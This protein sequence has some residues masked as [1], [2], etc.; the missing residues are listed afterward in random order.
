[1]RVTQ[2]QTNFWGG[3]IAT[4]SQGYADDELYKAS[5]AEITNFVVTPNGGL[6][7]RPGTKFVARTKPNAVAQTKNG[8][9]VKLVPFTLG[10]SSTQNF[11]LEFGHYQSEVTITSV[12]H[13]DN[14]FT[15]SVGHGLSSYDVIQ[16]E[17]SADDL[18][19]GVSANVDYHV[20]KISD[21]TFKVCLNAANVA[22]TTVVALSDNG[23]GTHKISSRGYC[24]FYKDGAQVLLS[25]KAFE[26]TTPYDTA[27]KINKLNFAQSAAFIFLVSPDVKPQKLQYTA[28]TTWALSNI[29]FFDGPYFGTQEETD[30]DASTRT[31]A[32]Q[33][34]SSTL[35]SAAG[36]LGWV[37]E[38]DNGYYFTGTP[39]TN[40]NLQDFSFLQSKNPGL[41]DGMKIQ[42]SGTGQTTSHPKDQD[43]YATQCTANTFKLTESVGGAPIDFGIKSKPTVKAYFYRKNSTITLRQSGSGIWTNTATDAGRLFR[44]NTLGNDQIYWG[45]VEIQSISTNDAT[46]TVKTDIPEAYT[47]GLKDWKLGQWYTS[48]Y[49]HHVTL[50][51]QRLVFARVDHSPQTIF[52]SQTGDFFNFAA[53]E[54]LGSATGQ[55]TASG[56]SII[57]EQILAS[58]AMTFTFDSGTVDEIQ[59]LIAQEKLLAG[60]TGGIYTVYGSE[61]DLTITPINFTIKREGTQPAEENSNAVA[62]DENVI[63]IQGTGKRVRLVNFGDV[64]AASKSFDMTIRAN[65]ILDGQGKQVVATQIPNFVNWIRDG[66]GK[67]VCVTYIPQNNVVAWHTHS[68]GGSYTY[69][70]ASTKADPTGHLTTDQSHAV[71][72][73]M[74]TIPA[75]N[76]DQ[77]WLLVRRVVGT[78]I[79]E[80]IEVMETWMSDEAIATSRFVDGHVVASTATQVTGMTHLE[81]QTVRLLGDGAQLDDQTVSSGTADSGATTNFSTLVAGLGYQSKLV[82]LPVVVGPGGNVRIGNKKRIHRA[83]AKLFRTPNIKYGIYPAST[84]TDTISELVTRTTSDEYG[85]PP[86]LFTGVQ[87]MVPISQ[88]FT[89]GQFQI[90]M[91]DSLPVNILALEL[92]YETNDN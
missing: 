80:T 14:L 75:D 39:P 18:P 8:T 27:D 59:F 46:C 90:Q 20:L 40:T 88:G 33:S 4:Q 53:S 78:N 10:H 83:W 74:A 64:N 37:G 41:Q 65:D 86:T 51:Q 31:I 42:V 58:N 79:I 85:D 84:A 7:R 71:I 38:C 69:S 92:D 76:R 91:D 3:Q 68:I 15:V 67:L 62:T 52:F 29:D 47:T 19:D 28:D 70:D 26:I 60:T 50:F 87:E 56:A 32:V 11:V 82:T 1:M 49:P 25:S 16:L 36:E 17:T 57:G 89:D 5:S 21:T 30:G 48:N 34:T 77:L 63:Y 72:L 35:P 23:S 13:A 22:S 54:S 6:T 45:H 9:A 12:T 61:Q 81:G 43:Y 24:R 55:T 66:N 44:L 73:D 2:T